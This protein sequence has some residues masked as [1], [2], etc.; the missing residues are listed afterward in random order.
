MEA[1]STAVPPGSRLG[2]VKVRSCFMMFGGSRLSW[3]G[4]GLPRASVP[5]HQHPVDGVHPDPPVSARFDP[6]QAT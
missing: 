4:E 5:F 6:G 3:R 2:E 1:S